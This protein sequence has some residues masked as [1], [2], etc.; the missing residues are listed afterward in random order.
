MT[1]VVVAEVVVCVGMCV[2]ACAYVSVGGVVVACTLGLDAVRESNNG[3][4]EQPAERCFY[5]KENL[6][7]CIQALLLKCHYPPY[8][9]HSSMVLVFF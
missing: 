1:V 9:A 8:T 3:G 4:I 7:D 2:C 6:H 5:C